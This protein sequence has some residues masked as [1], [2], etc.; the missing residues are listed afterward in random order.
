MKIICTGC[1]KIIDGNGPVF[2]TEI[3]ADGKACGSLMLP[4]KEVEA[5]PRKGITEWPSSKE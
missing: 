3:L 4:F 1:G 5:K 2:C